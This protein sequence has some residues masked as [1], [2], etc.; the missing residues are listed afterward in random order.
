MNSIISCFF[1]PGT[2]EKVDGP[3][4]AKL[5]TYMIS[6]AAT[7]VGEKF[8]ETAEQDF[9]VA[10]GNSGKLSDNEEGRNTVGKKEMESTAFHGG[11]G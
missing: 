10:A 8:C 11:Q 7:L 2:I 9:F 6:E 3:R 4:Q 1:I 5:K